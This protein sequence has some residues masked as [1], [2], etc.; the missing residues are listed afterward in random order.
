LVPI[1][2]AAIL[3]LFAAS[4]FGLWELQLPT[5]FTTAATKSYAG[6]FGSLFMGLTLG[7]VAA[8]CLGP[9][10]L[11]LLTW[12][13]SLGDPFQGFLIF[14]TLSL[15]LG[16]P[17][18]VL[19]LFSGSLDKLPHSGEW[20]LWVKKLMGW[21]LIGMAAHF[22]RPLL[23]GSIGVFLLAAVAF[24][25]GLHLGWLDRAEASFRGFDWLRTAAGTAGLV[26]A[27]FL[28]GSWMMIGPGV[29]WHPCSDRILEE[30][31]NVKKP[32]II[33]FSAEW[34]TPCRELEEVTFHNP[35][36]V[37]QA[38]AD[39]VMVKVDLTG[40]G[41]QIRKRALALHKVKGVPTVI[42]LDREGR[43]RRDLRLVDFLPPDQFLIRMGRVRESQALGF[44][45]EKKK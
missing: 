36:V 17:L 10:V 38:E 31:R 21:V 1:V 2:I 4:L 3:V 23:P 32:V 43:E 13:A 28:I 30:A 11:G 26:L 9:F 7:V 6:Y 37:K 14:F 20:M 8:P 25:A 19:G 35:D 5:S 33:D 22:I 29:S 12:V 34:C 39:F 24:S 15:G 18:V 16:L 45:N 27:T 40:K 44:L 42:F 41:N